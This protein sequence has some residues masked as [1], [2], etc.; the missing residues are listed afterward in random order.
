MRVAFD[1]LTVFDS[2]GSEDTRVNQNCSCIAAERSDE[3]LMFGTV[4]FVSKRFPVVGNRYGIVGRALCQTGDRRE[5]YGSRLRVEDC[6][7]VGRRDTVFGRRLEC[8][9]FGLARNE[10]CRALLAVVS[11]SGIGV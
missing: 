10:I 11:P 6:L 7:L 2:L 1:S 9:A 8:P 5:S 3:A 4:D